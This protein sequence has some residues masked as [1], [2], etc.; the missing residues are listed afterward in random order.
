MEGAL[1]QSREHF[2]E[3]IHWFRVEGRLIRVKICRFKNIRVASSYVQDLFT[4]SIKRRIRFH[5]VVVQWTSRKY[6]KKCDTRTELLFCSQNHFFYVVVVAV[7]A[8]VNITSSQKGRVKGFFPWCRWRSIFR[9]TASRLEQRATNTVVHSLAGEAGVL[10]SCF[11]QCFREFF[12][13]P[14]KDFNLKDYCY[15]LLT[16]WSILAQNCGLIRISFPVVIIKL[17]CWTCFDCK[18]II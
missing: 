5:V 15:V 13:L 3:W 10:L 7:A 12:S 9:L 8:V 1:N 14:Q 16:H 18:Q 4:S 6:S 11:Y 2:R 17:G